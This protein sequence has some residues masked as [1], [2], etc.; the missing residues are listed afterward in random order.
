MA[1][2]CVAHQSAGGR[3]LYPT[4]WSQRRPGIEIGS[5][6]GPGATR[7]PPHPRTPAEPQRHARIQR[8]AE[9]TGRDQKSDSGN[10]VLWQTLSS[11]AS[12]ALGLG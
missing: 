3:K 6:L 12:G 8:E 11:G 10:R 1:G 4:G 9:R 5:L 2:C 7:S